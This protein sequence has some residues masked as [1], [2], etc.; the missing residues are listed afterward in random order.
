MPDKQHPSLFLP[1]PP[2]YSPPPPY[3]PP[4]PQLGAAGDRLPLSQ[5]HPHP[6]PLELVGIAV[7]VATRARISRVAIR[8]DG[9][10]LNRLFAT[11]LDCQLHPRSMRHGGGEAINQCMLCCAL[12]RGAAPTAANQHAQ[13]ATRF[14]VRCHSVSSWSRRQHLVRVHNIT[15]RQIR[16]NDYEYTMTNVGF[17]VAAY[18]LGYFV[19]RFQQR[20]DCCDQILTGGKPGRGDTLMINCAGPNV[21]TVPGG[22]RV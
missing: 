7:R 18:A 1:L 4:P 5:Q 19:V 13:R 8:N 17:N 20:L 2:S 10:E 11:R 16:E 14:Q 21:F 3:P 6:C 9:D 15:A 12:A 22:N